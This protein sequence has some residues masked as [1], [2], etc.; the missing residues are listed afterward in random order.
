MIVEDENK[1]QMPGRPGALDDENTFL[2]L[3]GESMRCM[4][5]AVTRH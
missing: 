5:A 3:V 1:P 2:R 4:P